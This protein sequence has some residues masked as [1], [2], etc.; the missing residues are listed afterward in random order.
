MQGQQDERGQLWKHSLSYIKSHLP[1]VVMV[2]N[3]ANLISF[4][5]VYQE[6]VSSLEGNGYQILNKDNPVINAKHHGLPQSRPRCI[7]FGVHGH[8]PRPFHPPKPLKHFLKL[9]AIIPRSHVMAE[10]AHAHPLKLIVPFMFFWA[11][12][13]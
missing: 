6:I 3:V 8:V 11:V 5:D 9:S 1:K 13:E 10:S 7:L 4:K 12:F 2:E